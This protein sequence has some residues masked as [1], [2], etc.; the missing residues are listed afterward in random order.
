MSLDGGDRALAGHEDEQLLDLLAQM[1]QRYDPPPADLADRV[2]FALGLEDLEVELMRLGE[3]ELSA[4]GARAD[5]QVRAVTFSSDT[6]SVMVM[7]NEGFGGV[8][9][10]GWIDGGG[11][12]QVTLRVGTGER[13]TAADL[14]GR[15]SFEGVPSGLTQ[16][17]F[18]PTEGAQA[19]LNRSVVTPAIQV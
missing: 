10:D 9:L 11:G 15:F 12:L 19:R 4:A 16:L 8:R 2:C 5:E 14:D 18:L 6:L 7:I 1:W 3:Q 17:V 13:T